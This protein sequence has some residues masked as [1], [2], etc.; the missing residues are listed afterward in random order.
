M[1]RKGWVS[2]LLGLFL[3]Q[4]CT[5]KKPLVDV[6]VDFNWNHSQKME[7]FL[8]ENAWTYNDG[9]EILFIQV[10]ANLRMVKLYEKDAEE[11]LGHV[12]KLTNYCIQYRD[13]DNKE[14]TSVFSGEFPYLVLGDQEYD[15]TEIRRDSFTLANFKDGESCTFTKKEAGQ[16]DLNGDY[17][18]NGE[19]Y[20]IRE[21]KI[22]RKDTCES[23]QLIQLD[24]RRIKTSSQIFSEVNVYQWW[25]DEKG[26]LYLLS[27]GYDL[28]GLSNEEIIKVF[29][30]IVLEKVEN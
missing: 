2:L 26:N 30:F 19:L 25:K 17:L 20:E 1:K 14:G 5:Y 6:D 28:S 8:I 27:E 13:D 3:L 11:N 22:V 16:A 12:S 18:Y 29:P 21:D 7:E 24:E 4:G 15:F 10:G 9:E 23:F